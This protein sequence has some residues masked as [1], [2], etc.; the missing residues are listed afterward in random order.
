MNGFYW[1]HIWFL[2]AGNQTGELRWSYLARVRICV[3]CFRMAHKIGRETIFHLIRGL[4]PTSGISVKI[5]V[6]VLDTRYIQGE[7]DK[8][9]SCHGV[10]FQCREAGSK[11]ANLRCSRA[12]DLTVFWGIG[13]LE[14]LSETLPST[15]GFWNT[16]PPQSHN[17]AVEFFSGC[18]MYVIITDWMQIRLWESSCVLLSWMAEVCKNVKHFHSHSFICH[19]NF[20]SN[21]YL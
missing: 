18:M 16:F 10:I 9:L 2:I 17:C 14:A 1:W 4:S 20:N 7:Q 13:V 19:K 6:T 15:N 11:W 8:N 5:P 3:D 12:P 21:C